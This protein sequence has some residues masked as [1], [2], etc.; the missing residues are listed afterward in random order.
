MP[1]AVGVHAWLD[2]VTAED[3][4]HRGRRTEEQLQ[5][6]QVVH[7]DTHRPPTVI[8]AVPGVVVGVELVLSG[9]PREGRGADHLVPHDGVGERDGCR[10]EAH[11]LVDHARDAGGLDDLNDLQ[12]L[13]VGHG[14]RLLDQQRLSCGGDLGDCVDARRTVV[15]SGQVNHPDL[16]VSQQLG[17]RSV[18]HRVRLVLL[19]APAC[20]R[21]RVEATA[22][23]LVVDAVA[24]PV[25][26]GDPAQ[27]HLADAERVLVDHFSA[28]IDTRYSADPRT[29]SS[30]AIS[31]VE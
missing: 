30:P 29:A 11:V 15:R 20:I 7:G 25:S 19:Q 14:Q 10:A 6:A 1:V 3:R 16:V 24:L 31:S 21:V 23:G 4:V 9:Q 5:Q 8:A 27:A 13:G 26:A 18:D 22:D 17:Q 28:P 12:R 2:R